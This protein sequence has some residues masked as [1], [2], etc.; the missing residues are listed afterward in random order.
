MIKKEKLSWGEL[1]QEVKYS[2]TMDIVLSC[3]SNEMVK[4]GLL[5]QKEAVTFVD[6]I[7]ATIGGLV[8]SWLLTGNNDLLLQAVGQWESLQTGK[9]TFQPLHDLD[10]GL[11]GGIASN[12][13]LPSSYGALEGSQ[14]YIFAKMSGIELAF[15]ILYLIVLVI[16]IIAGIALS[17]YSFSFFKT[18]AIS[19]FTAG[20]FSFLVNILT[21][22]DGVITFNQFL[23]NFVG[24]LFLCVKLTYAAFTTAPT[25]EK[26]AFG[27][28]A[29]ASGIILVLQIILDIIGAG[30]G[31]ILRIAATVVM[32]TAYVVSFTTDCLDVD[33]A[34]G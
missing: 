8:T 9:A 12:I 33:Y 5:T 7:D 1:A 6:E 11:G 20:L 31:S 18:A 17:V 26:A 22:L 24:T 32:V 23:V 13:N 19:L 15:Y 21:Y 25:W 14:N 28:L 27:L 4:D 10:D 34:V 30:A 29:A 16:Q 2:P 3:Y